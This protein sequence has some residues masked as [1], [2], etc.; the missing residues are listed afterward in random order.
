[1]NILYV[2]SKKNWGGVASWM[3]KTAIGLEEKGHKVIILSAKKSRFTKEAPSCL[4]LI[5]WSFGF[6]YN[7][8]TILYIIY[9][10]KKYKIDLI[11]T[12][13]EKE[14]AVGG[15][16]AKICGIPNIRRVGRHDDFNDAKKK[17][18][19]RHEKFVDQCIIPC[20]AL[21]DEA[22]EH[23]SWLR[24]EQFSTIYNGRNIQHFSD[25]EI[26]E[27]RAEWGVLD[28][29]VII[30]VTS[31]LTDVKRIDILISAF[32]KLLITY[33]N[34]KLVISGFGKSEE[35]LKQKCNNLNILENVLFAGFTS[36]PLLAAAAYDIA[37]STSSNEGFPNTIV[38]YMAAGT[39]V[40]STDV[41]G[42][43]EIIVDGQNGFII[44]VNDP[45]SLIERL[46]I[47]LDDKLL[48]ERI[49]SKAHERVLNGFSEDKM[50]NELE[51]FFKNIIK[52]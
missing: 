23:S 42:V 8:K 25:I 22:V 12:N 44:P 1:M 46:I 49:G 32:A 37:V 7:P 26:Q 13:I 21:F 41:G 30:G 3:V 15:I 14:I 35:A 45:E 50:V 4:N 9:L 39:P 27:Q 20:N 2:S 17:I 52:K 24:K 6:D 48:C 18:R 47:L 29:T 33:K 51:H 11:V 40:V 31:Q 36:T 5:P 28:D 43:K 19:F 10:V 38:E 16:A 34:I